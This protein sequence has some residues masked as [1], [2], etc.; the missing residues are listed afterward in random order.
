MELEVG[1]Y[2]RT[3]TGQIGKITNFDGAMARV[4]TDKFIAYKDFNSEITKASHNIIDLIEVEDYVNGMKVEDIS[5][6]YFEGGD[7]SYS[8]G[9]DEIE[10]IVTKEQFEG[11]KYVI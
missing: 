9:F 10:S 5:L 1:M 7:G 2:V 6:S 4:D 11:M 8:V 3:E